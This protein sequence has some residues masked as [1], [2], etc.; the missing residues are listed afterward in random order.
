M[1]VVLSSV[2]LLQAGGGGAQGEAGVGLLRRAMALARAWHPDS[3]DIGPATCPPPTPTHRPILAP[4]QRMTMLSSSEPFMAGS[5]ELATWQAAAR[6]LVSVERLQRQQAREAG[7]PVGLR[8]KLG[9]RPVGRQAGRQAGPRQA[10]RRGCLKA[11]RRVP[12]SAC[13]DSHTCPA[14]SRQLPAPG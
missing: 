4:M 1:Q 3:S 11:A 5:T 12:I 14:T 13:R 10:T 9:D 6:Q 2:T 7:A 8:Q